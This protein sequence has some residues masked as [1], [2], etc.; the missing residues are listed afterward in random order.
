[1]EHTFSCID[2]QDGRHCGHCNKCAERRLA[3]AALEID[4][5]TEYARP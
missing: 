1:L 2:P 3:F 5:V 4:D